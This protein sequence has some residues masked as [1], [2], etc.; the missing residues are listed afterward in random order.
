MPENNKQIVRILNSSSFAT[1]TFA[2]MKQI[3][4][5]FLKKFDFSAFEYARVY[6]DGTAIIL[7]SDPSIAN[8]VVSK[9]LHI[10][11]HVNKDI[12]SNEFW[13]IPDQ[14]GPYSQQAK[15]IKGTPGQAWLS[16]LVKFQPGE[17]VTNHPELSVAA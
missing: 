12:V 3:C 15:D 11:A 6:D 9:E 14:N 13:F 5:P 17:G 8:Y 2:D 10:S 1:Q 7:Y 16:K 4:K